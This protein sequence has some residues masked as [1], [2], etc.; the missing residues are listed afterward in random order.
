MNPVDYSL[1]RSLTA[2]RLE[3]AL[4]R[5]GFRIARQRGSHRRYSHPDG[6]RVTVP[7][8]SA[9]ETFLPKT[10]KSIIERQ[11]HWTEADLQ[12]LGLLK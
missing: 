4:T 8:S 2:R 5:E 7:F 12:R 3:K 1:L 11:A 10:L 6:R 9:G